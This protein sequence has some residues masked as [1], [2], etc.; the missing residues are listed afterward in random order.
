MYLRR[1]AAG[2]AVAAALAVGTAVPTASP[3]FAA[4]CWDPNEDSGGTRVETKN[5]ESAVFHHGPYG[6]CPGGTV[7]RRYVYLTC[8]YQNSYGSHWFHARDI[9]WIYHSYL[10]MSGSEW[11]DRTCTRRS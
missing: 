1:L 2:L 10:S 8:H 4:D 7:Y 11:P 6:A 9:G 3:A 5:G